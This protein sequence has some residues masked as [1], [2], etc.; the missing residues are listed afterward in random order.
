MAYEE[1]VDLDCDT[2]IKLG[3]TDKKTG[4]KNPTE[5]EGYYLGARTVPNKKSKTGKGLIHVFKTPS[6]NTGVWGTTHLD[7]SLSQVIAGVMT[8]VTFKGMKETPNNPMYYY[9]VKFDNS[10]RLAGV[11]FMDTMDTESSEGSYNDSDEYPEDVQPVNNA[12]K[13]RATGT[14]AQDILSRRNRS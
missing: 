13:E 9:G 10:N 3:G 8:L 2:V 7:R 11:T 1:V 5:I 12:F 14:T 6:G 4:K